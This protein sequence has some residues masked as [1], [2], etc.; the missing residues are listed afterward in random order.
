MNLKHEYVVLFCLVNIGG[1]GVD[2]EGYGWKNTVVYSVVY[3][4]LYGYNS[5][6]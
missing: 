5:G 6:S 1:M 4:K 2:V 3:L